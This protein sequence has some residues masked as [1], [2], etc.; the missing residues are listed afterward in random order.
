[1]LRVLL[2]RRF[3]GKVALFGQIISKLDLKGVFMVRSSL[4]SAET[5]YAVFNY[6]VI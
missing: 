5:W 6:R 1:M 3:L 2:S 4:T